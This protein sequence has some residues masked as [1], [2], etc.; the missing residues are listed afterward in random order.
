MD[1]KTQK[2]FDEIVAK[3][4][5]GLDGPEIVFLKARI[6]YLTEEQLEKFASVLATDAP[7]KKAKKSDEE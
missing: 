4:V 5:S 2:M 3:D 7:A 1:E 6:S